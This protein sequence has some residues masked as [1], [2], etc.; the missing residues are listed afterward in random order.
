MGEPPRH[1]ADV[2]EPGAGRAAGAPDH[3]EIGLFAL[4]DR[5]DAWSRIAVL[6]DGSDLDVTE[7]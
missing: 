5:E 3:D 6:D 2:Q 7:T 4:G 1:A